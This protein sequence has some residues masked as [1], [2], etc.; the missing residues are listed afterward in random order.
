MRCVIVGSMACCR[1]LTGNCLGFRVECQR[2]A[3]Q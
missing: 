2:A 3:A 1:Q